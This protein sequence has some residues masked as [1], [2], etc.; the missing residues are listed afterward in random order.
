MRHLRIVVAIAGLILLASACGGDSGAVTPDFDDPR[1]FGT[2]NIDMDDFKF[3]P[4]NIRLTTGQHIR[5]VLSNS[6]AKDSAVPLVA[7]R[8]ASLVW[9]PMARR[10]VMKRRRRSA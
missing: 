4:D 7:V 10:R 3:T 5:I 2:L 9:V 8:L 1:G 6:S